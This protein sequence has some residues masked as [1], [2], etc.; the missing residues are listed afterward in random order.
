[1]WLVHLSQGVQKMKELLSP[2]SLMDSV[3]ERTLPGELEKFFGMRVDT[4]LLIHVPGN[5][6]L[7]DD[8]AMEAS[9]LWQ[10]SYQHPHPRPMGCGSSWC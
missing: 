8:S 4:G 2:V 6:V 7:Y 5:I 3:L 9:L 10:G 1:M